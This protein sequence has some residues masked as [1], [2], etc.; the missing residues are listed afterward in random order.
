MPTKTPLRIARIAP[1]LLALVAVGCSATSS[2]APGASE[3]L[4]TDREDALF[5]ASSAVW[6]SPEISVCWVNAGPEY[7]AQKQWT[8]DAVAGT[9]EAVSAVRF[10]GWGPCEEKSDGIRIMI[11]EEN[12]YSYLG[13]Q[14][15]GQPHTMLL[16]FTFDVWSSEACKPNLEFCVRTIAVHE[17]GHALAFDHEQNRPDSP[18][19]CAKDTVGGG[20]SVIGPWD[21]DSVMNYCNPEWSGNGQLSETDILGV[22][23]IYG[24]SPATDP[25]PQ[26][27]PGGEPEAGGNDCGALTYQGECQGQTVVWCDNG[28]QS[29]DCESMG[30]QCGWDEANNFYNC[31]PAQ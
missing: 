23:T 9:W 31:I 24:K 15:I 8:R 17:F 4:S 25:A 21:L 18:S 27:D 1:A 13:T 19:W 29:L 14:G 30:M 5:V 10:T 16:N 11:A 28:K 20:D 26:P 6:P 22:Q 7:E 3:V 2:P 12:P